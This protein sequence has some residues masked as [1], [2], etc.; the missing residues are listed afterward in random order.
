MSGRFRPI[1]NRYGG[2]VLVALFCAYGFACSGEYTGTQEL[3]WKSGYAAA[4]SG[5][6]MLALWLAFKGQR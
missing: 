6:L 5:A 3:A 1:V 2:C 4:G